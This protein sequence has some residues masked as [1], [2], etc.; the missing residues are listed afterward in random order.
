MYDALGRP[1]VSIANL[2]PR[3]LEVLRRTA[4]GRTNADVATELGVTVHAV[5]FHL[6]S[7]FRKLDVHNRTEAAAM[8][9]TLVPSGA[10]EDSA[11]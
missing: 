6:A 1:T 3:E 4:T 7:I 10:V 9:L 5:K 8:Y 11:P 2:T